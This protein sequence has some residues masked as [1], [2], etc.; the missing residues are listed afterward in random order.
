MGVR[1]ATTP[2][3]LPQKTNAKDIGRRPVRNYGSVP[4][5]KVIPDPSQPRTEFDEESLQELSAS[6]A[7]KGQLQPIRVRWLESEGSWTII[8]GERRWRAAQ[9][10][11]LAT[12]DCFFHEDELSPS[13][14]LEEQIIENLQRRALQ[15]ME[16]ARSFDALIKM[17]GWKKK[18]AAEALGIHPAKVS[19]ALKLLKLPADIQA[20]I[21]SGELPAR[22][23]YEIS[24][25][26]DQSQQRAM[27]SDVSSEGLTNQ[28]ARNRVRV[29]K[30]K[31]SSQRVGTKLTFTSDEN[32]VIV[33]SSPTKTTY[34][35]IEAALQI[36][37]ED[38][39]HRIENNVQV[40]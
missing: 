33:V 9:M 20:K 25:L 27:L 21:E 36:A 14:I 22:T 12:I 10:A 4:I 7:S 35:A 1:A 11:G 24:K 13:E 5:E 30:G 16:E 39:R 38:V 18:Q 37:L 26:D 6:F 19:R 15:P 28:E 3:A 29:K 2:A 23:A 8:A 40:A 32:H 31:G 34:E 17:N